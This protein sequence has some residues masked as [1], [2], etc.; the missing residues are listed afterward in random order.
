MDIKL[1]EVMKFLILNNWSLFFYAIKK[2]M[3]IFKNATQYYRK[4]SYKL[5]YKKVYENLC[6]NC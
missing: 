2:L 6:L 1:F 4:A 3:T 5:R